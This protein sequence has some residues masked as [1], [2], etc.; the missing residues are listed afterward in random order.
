MILISVRPFKTRRIIHL[1]TRTS[2]YALSVRLPSVHPVLQSR[3]NRRFDN[4]I[5]SQS[6]P[7]LTLFYLHDR[8]Q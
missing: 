2:I 5:R 6:C 3:A 1:V 4:T 8:K 7:H